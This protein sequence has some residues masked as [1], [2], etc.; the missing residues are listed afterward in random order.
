LAGFLPGVRDLRAPLVSGVLWI[1]ALLVAAPGLIDEVRDQSDDGSWAEPLAGLPYARVI[2]LA[3][4]TFLAYLLGSIT[5]TVTTGLYRRWSRRPVVAAKEVLLR[6]PWITE[7]ED[8]ADA[9]DWWREVRDLQRVQLWLTD[10]ELA[11]L[12]AVEEPE[13][14]AAHAVVRDGVFGS[15]L[16]AVAAEPAPDGLRARSWWR[17]RT[18]VAT[19]VHRATM[20]MSE[21]AFSRIH[22]FVKAH[23]EGLPGP[24]LAKQLSLPTLAHPIQAVDQKTARRLEEITLVEEIIRGEPAQ[25]LLAEEGLNQL[26]QAY[27]R[28]QAEGQLRFGLILPLLV[29]GPV[30]LARLEVPVG[31]AAAL[32]V[33]LLLFVAALLVQGGSLLANACGVLAVAISLRKVR[34]PTVM[35][36]DDLWA[37]LSDAA[38]GP[39]A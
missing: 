19:W 3:A 39:D 21:S 28:D 37:D 36:V 26:F 33:G 38:P 27:D 8:L 18:T 6:V 31:G 20:P 11:A 25:A 29:L 16:P 2:G 22:R 10:E 7:R 30:L 35:A 17:F 32:L 14:I 5:V 15:T 23:S 34:T 4:L 24:E 9:D 1:A 13:V 12:T